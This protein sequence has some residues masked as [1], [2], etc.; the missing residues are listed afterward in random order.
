MLLR[1][2]EISRFGGRG[3]VRKFELR[4]RIAVNQTTDNEDDESPFHT[5]IFYFPK[6][7]ENGPLGLA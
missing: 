3:P 1:A 7:D 6:E 4:E 5:Y 2:L